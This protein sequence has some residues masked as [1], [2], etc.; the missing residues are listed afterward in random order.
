MEESAAGL[1]RTVPATQQDATR[2]A[3]A[4]AEWQLVQR[5]QRG[6]PEA[7]GRLY[8]HYFPRVYQ[9]AFLQ[10]SDVQQAEDV[11]SDVMLQVVEAL[12]RFRF[13]GSPFGAWL[14]RIAR[15]RVI[16]LHRRRKRRPQVEV[17]DGIPFEGRGPHAQA[18]RGQEYNR[19]RQA[20]GRLTGDQR[21]VILLKFVEEMDNGT[22]AAVLGRSEGAVKSL[23]HRA[24]VALKKSLSDLDQ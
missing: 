5:A 24:L 12:P 20:I 7:L 23:Q 8:E 3:E 11:A 2:A 17:H 10:L 21:Q 16:D 1:R 19:L 9:Y 18:E 6:E 15:N 14:F 22:V 4:G 13:R